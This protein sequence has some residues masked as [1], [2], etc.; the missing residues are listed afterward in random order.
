MIDDQVNIKDLIRKLEEVKDFILE[1]EKSKRYFSAIFIRFDY[2]L[3]FRI[4]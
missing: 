4:N 3:F 1:R 2:S